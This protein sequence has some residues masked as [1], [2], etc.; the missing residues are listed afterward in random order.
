MIDLFSKA[1][2]EAKEESVIEEGSASVNYT[3]YQAIVKE[4]ESS[5]CCDV[6]WPGDRHK[7]EHYTC[8]TDV[9]DIDCYIVPCYAVEFEYNGKK[10]RARGL[11]IGKANEVHDT[12]KANGTVETVEDVEN[13]RKA[14]V[15]EKEKPLKFFKLCSVVAIIAGL[16]G[17]YGLINLKDGAPGVKVCLPVGFILMAVSIAIAVVIKGKV[18]RAVK[19]VNAQAAAE[20][21]RLNDIKINKLEKVLRSLSFTALSAAEKNEIRKSK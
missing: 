21:N 3:A 2:Q 5:A 15:A 6:E 17:L 18:K 1:Y 11:A 9:K 19:E 12:P 8:K 14:R 20:K 4:C 13:R 7:D 16:I 10:Y